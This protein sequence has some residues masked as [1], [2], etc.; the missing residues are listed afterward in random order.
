MKQFLIA[1]LLCLAALHLQAASTSSAPFDTHWASGK[2]DPI[3]ID[4]GQADVA[5]VDG[6]LRW[7][8]GE[9]GLR[10]LAV[11]PE[12]AWI[13]ARL[14]NSGN[15]P[16]TGWI[17]ISKPFTDALDCAWRQD[18]RDTWH[19][20]GDQRPFSQRPVDANDFLLPVSLPP[21]SQGELTCRITNNGSLVADL[22][23]W[24]PEA[25]QSRANVVAFWRALAYGSLLFA[26]LCGVAISIASRHM[27]AAWMVA[28]LIP[29]LLGTWGMEGDGFRHL[30]P[31]HPEL[32]V[33]P[34]WWLLLG[35]MI[36]HQLL[37]RML[38]LTPT[39]QRVARVMAWS[40]GILLGAALMG[41]DLGGQLVSW[42]F[43]VTLVGGLSYAAMCGRHWRD[44]P[45]AKVLA[46]GM[47]LQMLGVLINV[48][49]LYGNGWLIPAHTPF[50][51]SSLLSS[52][53]KSM[54]LMTAL[55]LK[56]RS[57]RHAQQKLQEAYT[58][59]LAES[60]NRERQLSA[61]QRVDPFYGL[62]S[63]RALDQSLQALD[64]QAQANCTVWL[65]RLNRIPALQAC[66]PNEVLTSAVKDG[67][68]QLERWLVMND[69]EPIMVSERHFVCAAGEQLFAFA[70]RCQP[71]ASQVHKLSDFLLGRHRWQGMYLAWDPFVGHGP[72]GNTH[73]PGGSI[74][75]ARSALGLTSPHRRT[76]AYDQKADQGQQ[77]KQGLTLDID[78][79]ITRHELELHYQPKVSLSLMR[80]Q[81]FEAL[82]R[83][84]HPEKGLI[85]P[86]AFIGEAESTGII[87][88]IT[89]WAVQ[90]AARFIRYIDDPEVKIAVN[91]S[92]YDLAVPQFVKKVHDV[93]ASEGID[94]RR[95]ILEIT[96]SVAM[97]QPTE[98]LAVLQRLKHLGVCIALDDFGT[99]QSSLSLLHDIPID[100]VKIDRALVSQ[101]DRLASKQVVLKHILQMLHSLQVNV[102]VEG[103]E[104]PGEVAWL[105]QNSAPVVQGYVF[106]K[107]LPAAQ[108]LAWMAA[109]V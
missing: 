32:N 57:D 61:L 102:T 31:N 19:A 100:E 44:S 56:Y 70:T 33:P 103:V 101:V 35:L 15:Q 21:Q 37:K 107:P 89:M 108:A 47:G 52:E 81:S 51:L 80:A 48:L 78:G 13:R 40:A 14:H 42:C 86:G 28:D 68:V 83:W 66:L 8:R 55:A 104:T 29:I 39:E 93:L 71:K 24:H 90:E 62:P 11:G 85:P 23:Y 73:S 20:M 4:V 17:Q 7:V 77:V 53:V 36:E 69:L 87:H 59:T 76:V 96:E 79:A 60:L 91:I 26:I 34:Y 106:S 5:S 2:G 54:A 97:D 63:L 9:P 30:W 6:T 84:R 67:L 99:G 72:L 27:L 94:G 38:I 46:I 64:A 1:W 95:L 50:Q 12:Q 18:G 82:V 88:K 105:R 3:D 22:K 16:R 92:A 109:H 41:L 45:V 25:Y 98:T 65:V 43:A 74:A 58:T 75:L 10:T 49:G